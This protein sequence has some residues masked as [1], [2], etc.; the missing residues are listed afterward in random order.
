MRL[1]LKTGEFAAPAI[2]ELIDALHDPAVEV[3]QIVP[4]VFAAIGPDVA[5]AIPALIAA[6]KDQDADVRRAVLDALGAIQQNDSVVIPAIAAALQDESEDVRAAAAAA[7]GKFGLP[8]AQTAPALVAALKDDN[9][10][11]RV[12]AVKS[13]AAIATHKS[14]EADLRLVLTDRD[15]RVRH[16]AAEALGIEQ[17]QEADNQEADVKPMVADFPT[18][19]Q[20]LNGGGSSARQAAAGLIKFCRYPDPNEG[21]SDPGPWL[22]KCADTEFAPPTVALRDPDTLVRRVAAE[23]MAALGPKAA[24]ALTNLMEALNDR[25]S[26][27]SESVEEALSYIGCAA[28]PAV[29]ALVRSLREDPNSYWAYTALQ[30]IGEAARPA[31]PRWY[32]RLSTSTPR[33]KCANGPA[34]PC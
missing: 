23:A 12:N 31:V 7:L 5:P 22:R 21:H 11:V 9:A 13:L 33:E 29:P 26:T 27:V 30:M 17:P 32:P 8:A 34:R 6:M 20:S 18:L 10:D 24:T 16:A 15:T 1:L 28:A 2:P 25:D 19:M 3:R 14:V 4:Q